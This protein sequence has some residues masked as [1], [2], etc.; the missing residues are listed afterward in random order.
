M[1]T[2]PWPQRS[3]VGVWLKWQDHKQQ[4]TEGE[5]NNKIRTK[6]YSLWYEID[7]HFSNGTSC[8]MYNTYTIFDTIFC[9]SSSHDVRL[10]AENSPTANQKLPFTWMVCSANTPSK[11]DYTSAWKD[12]QRKWCQK[13]YTFLLEETF[14]PG[15]Y[16]DNK[17]FL[18][19]ERTVKLLSKLIYLAYMQ[20]EK[21]WNLKLKQI[22]F[23]VETTTHYNF[24][25]L[26]ASTN[27]YTKS[28]WL[29]TLVPRPPPLK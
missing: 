5:R 18:S 15:M 3:V 8:L 22:Y 17:S 19:F 26:C 24:C 1:A 7:S 16:M 6:I 29:E 21:L 9:M 13:L 11:M 10:W 27:I 4:S 25:S 20:V 2:F 12:V 23:G 28:F 14:A